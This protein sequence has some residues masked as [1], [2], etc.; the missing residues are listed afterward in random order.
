MTTLQEIGNEINEENIKPGKKNKDVFIIKITN[1]L[2]D[3]KIYLSI[4]CCCFLLLLL[5]L[6]LI[7][8]QSSSYMYPLSP[9]VY[10]RSV[11]SNASYQL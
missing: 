1:Y 6:I 8:S 2:R 3:P 10:G 9:P 5:F 11:F 7:L 4:C